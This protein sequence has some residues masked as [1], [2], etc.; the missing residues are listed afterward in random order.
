MAKE[1]P[2]YDNV[3]FKI[4]G[5]VILFIT[6]DQYIDYK[7]NN[8]YSDPQL[9]NQIA[10]HIRPMLIFDHLG[11]IDRGIGVGPD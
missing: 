10:S 2:W 9:I 7:I 4:I 3:I 5:I 8:K 11:T 1:K 6:L